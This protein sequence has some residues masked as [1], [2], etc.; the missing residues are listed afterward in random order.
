MAQI[1]NNLLLLIVVILSLGAV[2]IFTPS[3]A[4]VWFREIDA[5]LNAGT[6]AVMMGVALVAVA[7]IYARTDE[8]NPLEMSSGDEPVQDIKLALVYFVVGLLLAIGLDPFVDVGVMQV[9]E[10]TPRAIDATVDAKASMVYDILHALLAFGYSWVMT[11]WVNVMA[12][13]DVAVAVFLM[14]SGVGCLWGAADAAKD[15]ETATGPTEFAD[16]LGGRHRA[17][18]VD[19]EEVEGFA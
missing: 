2:V 5:A 4:S 12:F 16:W 10:D 19:E 8:A 17:E 18:V 15:E 3:M 11:I 13:V 1:F 7:V 14:I 6:F 9:T